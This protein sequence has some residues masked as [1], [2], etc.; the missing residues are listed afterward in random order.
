[1]WYLKRNIARMHY[2]CLLNSYQNIQMI[3]RIAVWRGQKLDTRRDALCMHS[4]NLQPAAYVAN[5]K[6]LSVFSWEAA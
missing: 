3:V 5:T 1:M 6:F 4:A 2:C